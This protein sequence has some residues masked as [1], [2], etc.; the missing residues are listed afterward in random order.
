MTTKR[1]FRTT[2][3]THALEIQD[4]QSLFGVKLTTTLDF[5]ISPR[6]D[7][8]LK[9]ASRAIVSH[10]NGIMNHRSSIGLVVSLLTR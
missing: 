3:R 8:T 6:S 4:I 10:F 2:P 5:S 1:N 7:D 9:S